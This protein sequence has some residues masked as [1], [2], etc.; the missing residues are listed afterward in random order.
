MAQPNG[1]SNLESALPLVDTTSSVDLV[2]ANQDSLSA[3]QEFKPKP[4]LKDFKTY[5]SELNN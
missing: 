1:N 5:Q 2:G 3:S 4:Q